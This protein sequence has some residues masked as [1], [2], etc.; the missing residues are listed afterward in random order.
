LGLACGSRRATIRSVPPPAPA[1]P[2]QPSLRG[3]GWRTVGFVGALVV[4]YS[5]RV[6]ADG[7]T[8]FGHRGPA[9]PLGS[10]LGPLACPGC[11][12]L[13]STAAALQGDLGLAFRCHPAGP[14]VAALL[15]GGLLLHLDILRRRCEMPLHRRC[16]HWGRQLF[17]ATLLLGWS[18]RLLLP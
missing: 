10:C 18:L 8:W 15:L 4:G 2:S 14:A 3:A 13:R 6:T 9:C 17:V 7:A 5:A 16:R 1:S 12:L 11:G